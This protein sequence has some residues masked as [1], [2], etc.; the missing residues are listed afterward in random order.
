M[1]IAKVVM[2]NLFNLNIKVSFLNQNIAGI[3][4]NM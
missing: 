4:I 3:S 2:K 1:N